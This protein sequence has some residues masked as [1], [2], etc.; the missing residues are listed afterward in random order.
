MSK[1]MAVPLESLR[2]ATPS[3]VS[4]TGKAFAR[5]AS[6]AADVGT[7]VA[8]RA[9]TGADVGGAVAARVGAA[10]ADADG[11]AGRVSEPAADEPGR[12]GQKAPAA[13]RATAAAT[14][15]PTIS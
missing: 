11:V 13:N 5:G 15:A 1:P 12:E 6:A 7:K 4:C 3:I 2:T 9:T 8:G 10:V 14:A